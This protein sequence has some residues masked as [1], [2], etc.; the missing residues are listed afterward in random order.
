[1]VNIVV[2]RLWYIRLLLA[3]NLIVKIVGMEIW[4]EA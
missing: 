2:A 1:M 4:A 3:P